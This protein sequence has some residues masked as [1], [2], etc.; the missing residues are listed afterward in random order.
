MSSSAITVENLGKRYSLSSTPGL[1]AGYVRVADAL[2]QLWP[3]KKQATLRTDFWALRDLSFEVP[4]G[5]VLGII[6]RN[7]AG[8]STLLK[9]LSRITPPSQGRI[10]MRGRVASLLE[11]GTGFHPELTGR[12]NIF[13]NGAILG[14]TKGDIRARFDEIVA[15]AD[16][17]AFLDTPVKRYSSGMQVRLA[18]AVAAHLEPEILIVDEVLA[19]GDA[20]FQKRC[21]GRINSVASNGRTVLLVS[22]QMDLIKR[23]STSVLW[24]DRGKLALHGEPDQVISQY[25]CEAA[26]TSVHFETRTEASPFIDSIR[27]NREKLAQGD[28]EIEIGFRA[29]YPL[30]RPEIGLAIHAANGAAICGS[31]TLMHPPASAL[32][33]C[34]A[35]TA[36]FSL[37]QLPLVTGDYTVSLWLND[38]TANHQHLPHAVAFAFQDPSPAAYASHPSVTGW[39]KIEATWHLSAAE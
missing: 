13:L 16:A 20:Q 4:H 35:G 22:H 38:G 30:A 10:T 23:L 36:I 39:T 24:L 26:E 37:D 19:V 7:G 2:A 3:L 31:N 8:K 34:S 14:M 11:V 25:L 9:I 5:Q 33:S 6:G 27:I 12:E 17:E 32:H 18:F 21:L 1:G 15:F 28:L 29:P